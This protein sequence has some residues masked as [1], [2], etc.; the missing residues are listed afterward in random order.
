MFEKFRAWLKQESAEGYYWR[1]RFEEAIKAKEEF[2]SCQERL[3]KARTIQ[4]DG[5]IGFPIPQ[6]HREELMKRMSTYES[7]TKE[8]LISLL[9]QNDYDYLQMID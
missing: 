2:D 6:E 4:L 7:M 8:E 3:K 9:L 1:K 5:M